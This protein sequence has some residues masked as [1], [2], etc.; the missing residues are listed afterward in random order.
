MDSIRVFVVHADRPTADFT[1]SMLASSHGIRV[2]G[3]CSTAL[4]AQA[5]LGK[6]FATSCWCRRRFRTTAR[7][8]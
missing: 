6:A 5:R 4:E 7:T 1:A 8:N 2:S 3:H